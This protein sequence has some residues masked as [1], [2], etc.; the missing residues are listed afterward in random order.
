MLPPPQ[1]TNLLYQSTTAK[2]KNLFLGFGIISKPFQDD[3]STM[4]I[5]ILIFSLH[6]ERL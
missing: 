3:R 1:T 4:Y 6:V 2:L 5:K